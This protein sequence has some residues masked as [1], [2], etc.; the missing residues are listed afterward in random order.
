M[1]TPKLSSRGKIEMKQEAA[2]PMRS[3]RGCARLDGWLLAVSDL[4]G[5]QEAGSSK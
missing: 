4:A 5:S 1:M 3:W 2:D